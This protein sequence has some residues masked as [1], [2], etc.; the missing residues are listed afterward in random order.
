[1]TRTKVAAGAGA[2]LLAV[3]LAI[4]FATWMQM[5]AEDQVSVGSIKDSYAFDVKDKHQLMRH[6]TE[7]FVGEVLGPAETDYNA[8]STLWRVRVVR[9][10]KGSP[11]REVLVRQLGSVDRDGRTRA[12]EEQPLLLAGRRHLLVTTRVGGASENTLIAGP[13]ASVPLSSSV[14]E[15]QL[16]QQYRDAMP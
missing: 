8:G 14:H 1:M 16:V 10:I 2:A 7:V 6:G 9:S 15:Q 4:G 12:T 3:A 11:D 13:A 5:R